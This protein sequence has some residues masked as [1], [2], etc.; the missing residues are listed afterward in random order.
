MNT[1]IVDRTMQG[2]LQPCLCDLHLKRAGV[3]D[4]I[5][6]E[7]FVGLCRHSCSAARAGV[8]VPG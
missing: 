6:S 4:V 7:I 2:C 5:D 1:T 8:A 3:S